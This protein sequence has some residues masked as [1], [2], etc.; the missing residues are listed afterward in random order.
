MGEKSL[1]MWVNNELNGYSNKDDIPN[2]RIVSTAIYGTVASYSTRWTNHRLPIMHLDEEIQENLSQIEFNESIS[3]L[4]NLAK[5]DR[6]LSQ[7][8]ST[9]YGFLLSEGLGNDL[10]VESSYQQISVGQVVQIITLIRSRLLDFILELSDKFSNLEEDVDLKKE[11]EKMN[12]KE[13]FNHTIFGDNTT[14]IVGNDN[15]NSSHL[16]KL[17]KL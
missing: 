2:Y 16:L 4:M 10:V 1:L 5:S 12:T 9:K 17:V 14:I 8:L 11:S 3:T 7:S 13:L 15:S 6:P